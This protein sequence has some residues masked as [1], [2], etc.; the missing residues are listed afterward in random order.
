MTWLPMAPG[1]VLALLTVVAGLLIWWPP[2]REERADD[3]TTRLRRSGM[4]ALLLVAALRPG[5]PGGDIKVNAAD[6]DVYFVVDTTVSSVAEDY[7]GGKPRID[8]MRTDIKALASQLPGAHFSLLTFDHESVTRLPLTA[9]GAALASAADTFLPETSTWSQ[10]SSVTVAGAAL[11]RALERGRDSHPD[12]ARIVFYL[13]DGEQTAA[14][15]PDP[16]D[17]DPTLINGGAVLGYGSDQGGQMKETGTRNRGYVL[18]PTTGRPARSVIDEAE[19][20]AIADQL[21]VPYLHRTADD[22]AAAVVD[23][24]HLKEL[25]SL[26]ESGDSRGVGGRTELY[27]AALLLLAALA[28]WE[29]G[30]ALVVATARHAAP[31]SSGRPPPAGRAGTGGRGS[32]QSRAGVR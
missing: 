9:D 30:A 32:D 14:A 8:G 18:D 5:V 16:F 4:V 24:V 22:G 2:G 27:W 3:L 13:G 25:G 12:R 23:A 6:L 28:A 19:L 10:G 15:Q 1:P 31:R 7:A 20:T 21:G 11:T 17:I 26:R 29:V